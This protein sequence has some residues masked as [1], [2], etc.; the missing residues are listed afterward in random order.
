LARVAAGGEARSERSG[1]S[2]QSGY[3][4]ASGRFTQEDPIGLGGGINLYGF[5]GGDPI[6]F[7]DPFGLCPPADDKMSDCPKNLGPVLGAGCPA[8]SDACN[9]APLVPKTT[10]EAVVR[11]AVLLGAAGA[12]LGLTAVLD[13]VVGGGATATAAT[14]P[15]VASAAPKLEALAER[16]GMTADE[17]ITTA[18]NN[19]QKLVDLARG[20]NINALLARPDGAAGFIRVTLDPTM[21]RVI[22]AGLMRANSVANG[23]ASGRFLPIP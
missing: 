16:F 13:F 20:G 21:Q 17:I 7:S 15:V 2:A 10:K 19:G 14:L 4:P 9:S 5:A 22:S 18:V 11:G 12:G 6:T 8:I 3:D 1:L 23:I